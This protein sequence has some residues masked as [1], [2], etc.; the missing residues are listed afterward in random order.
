[1]SHRRSSPLS[2][3]LP[4]LLLLPPA[5][6]FL[7]DFHERRARALA[8]GAS[9]DSPVAVEAAVLRRV[10]DDQERQLEWAR[11]R[12]AQRVRRW[13]QLLGRYTP[14][15]A[16]VIRLADLSPR[17]NSLWVWGDTLTGVGNHTAVV[18]G[19]LEALVG[20]VK[21]VSPDRGI[22][23]IQ[24]VWDRYFRVRFRYREAWGFL[25]GSGEVDAAGRPLLEI[26]H[27][28]A[29][30]AFTEGDAVT[31]DGEDGYYPSGIPI[32]TLFRQGIGE[33]N[34]GQFMVRGIFALGQVSRVMLLVDRAGLE[35]RASAA[36][37]E[38]Q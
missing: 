38:E 19:D 15:G 21:G 17:R 10:F 34:G 24:T 37:K 28:G 16:D 2:W 14:L 18:H 6:N 13:S 25:Y 3:L 31:T 27:L 35:V 33:R 7:W 9:A 36:R 29:E 4:L 8:G 20:I 30:V 11:E 23:R 1:M 26:R 22:A 32:G 5:G 12:E